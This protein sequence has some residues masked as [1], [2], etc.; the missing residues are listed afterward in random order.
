MEEQNN[1][2]YYLKLQKDLTDEF[3]TLDSKIKQN[4]KSLIPVTLGTLQ[5]IVHD[6]SSLH[7]IIVI[8]TMR[9]YSYFNRKVKKIM[10]YYIRS[11]KVSLY[12]ASSFNGVNDTAIMKRDFYN[13]V[14][15]PV[16]Y[17]YLANMVSDMVDVK[18]FGV[19]KWPGGLR[20]SFQVAG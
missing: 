3:L 16:S 5:E 10:K 14:K 11:G 7:L 1:W 13:F 9:E 8:R 19:E 2:V 15:L 20:S 12:I 6:Q 17:K 4:G 18:E